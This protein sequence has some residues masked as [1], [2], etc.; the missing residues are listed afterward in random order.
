MH[1]FILVNIYVFKNKVT[2]KWW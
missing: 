1:V 2:L